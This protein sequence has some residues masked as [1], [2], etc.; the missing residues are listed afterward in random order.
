MSVSING[1]LS[2]YTYTYQNQMRGSLDKNDDA[3]WDRSELQAYADAYKKA[4]GTG[5]DVDKLMEKY[6]NEDGMIDYATQ[7][8][9]Y[10]DDA[11]GFSKLSSAANS[12]SDAG[13]TS[14][15][16]SSAPTGAMTQTQRDATLEAVH[17]FT[18]SYG[19]ELRP[20]LDMDDDGLWSRDELSEYARLFERS[21]GQKLDVDAIIEKYGNDDGFIDPL[22]QAKVLKDDALKLSALKSAFDEVSN[23]NYYSPNPV[24][25]NSV[26][27][28]RR[29][30]GGVSMQ[31]LLEGMS[32]SS[33]MRFSVMIQNMESQQNMLNEFMWTGGNA[34]GGMFALANARTDAMNM[35]RLQ[36]IQGGGPGALF[37]EMPGTG[38]N[39]SI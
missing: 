17:R 20:K 19:K 33:K 12:T 25:S 34:S 30:S 6:A 9:M 13:E 24:T 14:G 39:F 38:M 11:L 35:Y 4:T 2:Q 5:L 15:A 1:A 8:Q 16:A 32:S 21:T 29:Q 26:S 22:N 10:K 31:D 7:Q 18:Y 28:E 3:A 36:M 37:G 27:Q 23:V